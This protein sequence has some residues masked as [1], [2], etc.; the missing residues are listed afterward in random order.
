VSSNTSSLPEVVEEAALLIDPYSVDDIHNALERVITD[1]ELR[2]TLITRGFIQAKK[3]T[4]EK[5]AHQL[6]HLYRQLLEDK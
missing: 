4:W 2:D 1:Q 3:F 6:H 5:S